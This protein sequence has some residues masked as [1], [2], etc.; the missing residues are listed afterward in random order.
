MIEEKYSKRN[1]PIKIEDI[2][3]EF[4]C[5]FDPICENYGL[6][7]NLGVVNICSIDVMRKCLNLKKFKTHLASYLNAV[8]E[9]ELISSFTEQDY[10]ELEE[11]AL[12]MYGG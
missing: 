8:R 4:R 7:T 10:K 5:G 3:K 11:L 9:K 1:K 6:K 2:L 12:K